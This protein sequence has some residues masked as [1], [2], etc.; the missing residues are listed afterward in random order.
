M[1][2][3]N[4]V[5]FHKVI[6]MIERPRRKVEA[7][8]NDTIG[9]PPKKVKSLQKNIHIKIVRILNFYERKLENDCLNLV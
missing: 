4:D 7:C 5:R 8:D 2:F 3:I 1:K 9:S 6:L